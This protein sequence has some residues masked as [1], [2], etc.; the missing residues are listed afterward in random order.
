MY[1]VQP[2]GIAAC[3]KGEGAT[4]LEFRQTFLEFRRTLQGVLFDI[5]I[6]SADF[7]SF[8]REVNKFFEGVS[9]PTEEEWWEAVREAREGRIDVEGMP[10][11]N[12]DTKEPYIEVNKIETP[13]ARHN[14]LGALE[15]DLA[16]ALAA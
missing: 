15:P 6:D 13:K 12:A 5:S 14:V 16:G 8:K 7:R 1:G 10:I 3:G 2:G 9:K 4:Y 11:V